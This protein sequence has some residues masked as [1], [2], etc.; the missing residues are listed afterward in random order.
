MLSK[1]I[2]SIYINGSKEGKAEFSK[3]AEFIISEKIQSLGIYTNFDTIFY[4]DSIKNEVYN[5]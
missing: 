1:E 4:K 3:K 2:S 5:C